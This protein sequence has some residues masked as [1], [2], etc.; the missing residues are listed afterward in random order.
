MANSLQVRGALQVMAES[1]GENFPL[2]RIAWRNPVDSAAPLLRAKTYT[3]DRPNPN[4][5][6]ATA[7]TAGTTPMANQDVIALPKTITMDQ[8]FNVKAAFTDLEWAQ[9][10]TEGK[11][12]PTML[13]ARQA[14]EIKI[15]AMLVAAA[16][17]A[18]F[19][20]ITKTS[21]ALYD[22]AALNDEFLANGVAVGNRVLALPSLL[23]FTSNANLVSALIGRGSFDGF[24][25]DTAYGRLAYCHQLSGVS[26]TNGT[27]TNYVANGAHAIGSQSIVLKTGANTVVVGDQV[28]FAGSTQRYVVESGITAPGTIKIYPGLKVALA[29]GDAMTIATTTA[30]SLGIGVHESALAIAFGEE[31]VP[32]ELAN[33]LIMYEKATSN[34]VTLTYEVTREESQ[35]AHKLRF[36][37]GVGHCYAD[38]VVKYKIS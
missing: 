30:A 6:V 38:G 33:K 7:T 16:K 5:F 22:M 32:A 14:L 31:Q 17:T 8:D 4:Q 19:R 20:Q 26:F 3:L 36:I 37:A 11:L 1:F 15:E 29:D 24:A 23:H 9:G 10:A 13:S 2:T 21:D 28:T 35:F 25:M 18:A 34:N 12:S 27:G